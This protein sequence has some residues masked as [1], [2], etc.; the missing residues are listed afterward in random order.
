[1][2]YSRAVKGSWAT[3]G[4]TREIASQAE[5]ELGRELTNEEEMNLFQKMSPQ[6]LLYRIEKVNK[7]ENNTDRN[8]QI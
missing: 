3:S 4:A 5:V 1:M 6:T 8:D 2:N 7:L